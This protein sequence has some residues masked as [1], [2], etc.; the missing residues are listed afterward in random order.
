MSAMATTS[1]TAAL[2]TIITEAA[3]DR[4]AWAAGPDAE[5]GVGLNPAPQAAAKRRAIYSATAEYFSG[6][7][8]RKA[9]RCNTRE[10]AKRLAKAAHRHCSA[11]A[12]H[13][14]RAAVWS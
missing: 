14:L 8:A 7:L 9:A 1:T 5:L 13:I 2:V 12:E 10:K 4:A 3:A 11:T 6:P